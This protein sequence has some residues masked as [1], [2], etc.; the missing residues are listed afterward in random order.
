MVK[1][2]GDEDALFFEIE[3]ERYHNRSAHAD[4]MPETDG[5]AGGKIKQI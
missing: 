4:A 2:L 1:E 5:K 3:A